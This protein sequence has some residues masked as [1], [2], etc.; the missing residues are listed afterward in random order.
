MNEE[1]GISMEEKA[2]TLIRGVGGALFGR[3]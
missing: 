3:V 2:S 1:Y